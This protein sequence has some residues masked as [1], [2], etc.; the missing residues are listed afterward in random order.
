MA[1]QPK[2]GQYSPNKISA[3]LGNIIALCK[4]A[5]SRSTLTKQMHD[6]VETIKESSLVILSN[7]STDE[8]RNAAFVQNMVNAASN[9]DRDVPIRDKLLKL[10]SNLVSLVNHTQPLVDKTP[11]T[12]GKRRSFFKKGGVWWGA[13][14]DYE[15]HIDGTLSAHAPEMTDDTIGIVDVAENLEKYRLNAAVMRAQRVMEKYHRMAMYV[16]EHQ[17]ESVKVPMVL[18]KVHKHKPTTGNKPRLVTLSGMVFT[19]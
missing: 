18:Y 8:N 15:G 13:K 9:L 16:T 12:I 14:V 11:V 2:R 3:T 5:H 1:R 7:D 6:V 17:D 19:I 4:H 10:I